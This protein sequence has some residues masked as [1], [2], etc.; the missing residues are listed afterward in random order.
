[1]VQREIMSYLTVSILHKNNR[2]VFIGGL[3]FVFIGGNIH[4]GHVIESG[5]SIIE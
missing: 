2:N 3:L 5:F 1:M 4:L